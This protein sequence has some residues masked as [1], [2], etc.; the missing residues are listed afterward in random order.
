MESWQKS[1]G[2]FLLALSLILLGSCNTGPP[3]LSDKIPEI[4]YD[5]DHTIKTAFFGLQKLPSVA[6]LFTWDA[7][8]KSG[9]PVVFSHELDPE[10]LDPQDFEIVSEDGELHSP[11]YVTLRP[12]SEEFELRTVLLIGDYGEYPDN[13]PKIVRIKGDLM[14]RTGKNYKGQEVDVIPLEEGPIVSYAEHF[15]FD[16]DYPYKAKGPGCDCPREETAMVVRTVWA[17]GVRNLD[18]KQ[19]GEAELDRFKVMMV[20]DGDTIS[21]SPFE[22]GDLRD[23]DNNLDLC[24][25]IKGTPLKVEVLEN[26]TIDPREDPNPKTELNIISRW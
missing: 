13:E 16:E 23:N 22:F 21:V 15:I 19:P 10:S 9:M 24:L 11:D 2:L 5:R 6:V 26:T 7:P 25:S 14:T 20:N 1:S 17:G 12:A 18:G 8:G 4:D 3:K